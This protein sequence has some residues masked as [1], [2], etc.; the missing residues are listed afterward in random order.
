MKRRAFLALPIVGA[1]AGIAKRCFGSADPVDPKQ[2]VAW[3]CRSDTCTLA[4]GRQRLMLS[5]DRPTAI[6]DW[7]TGETVSRVAAYDSRDYTVMRYLKDRE[8]RIAR[9]S[10]GDLL[11]LYRETR[12]LRLHGLDKSQYNRPL[13]TYVPDGRSNVKRF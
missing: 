13:S 7:W 1:I 4:D 6:T 8:G 11:P 2:I 3:D 12:K 5:D 10:N 9:A